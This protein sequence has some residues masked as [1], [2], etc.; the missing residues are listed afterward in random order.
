[1]IAESLACFQIYHTIDRLFYEDEIF[2][3]GNFV[4]HPVDDVIERV[5]CQFFPKYTRGRPRA[6]EWYPGWP[7]WI[8]NSR[9]NEKDRASIKIKNWAACIPEELRKSNFMTTVPFD[10]APHA[11]RLHPSP[12]KQGVVPGSRGVS[13]GIGGALG[14]YKGAV[15]GEDEDA[16]SERR[17]QMPTTMTM[18]GSAAP[19]PVKR[20]VGRPPK[21]RQVQ[22]EDSR[23]GRRMGSG[24]PFGGSYEGSP[25]PAPNAGT[26]YGGHQL[27]AAG[28]YGYAPPD[29][30]MTM[31]GG[32]GGPNGAGGPSSMQFNPY[33]SQGGRGQ[34]LP[35]G[36]IPPAPGHQPMFNPNLP[37]P[38]GPPAG[39]SPRMP[40]GGGAPL[41][42]GMPMHPMHHQQ[43]IPSGVGPS[44]SSSSSLPPALAP[45]PLAEFARIYGN[46]D[47]LRRMCEV[48][49]LPAASGE[50]LSSAEG[51]VASCPSIPDGL[52]LH[53]V[54]L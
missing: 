15:D 29:Y 6:P 26:P 41:P 23:D 34:P 50:C 44:S 19:P 47:Q 18:A 49:E 2:K 27:P 11:L 16:I 12:F 48:E 51:R 14:S 52:F 1:M 40:G 7:L 45:Q 31:S 22:V 39:F 46:E 8:S 53:S 21:N 5:G 36:F 33:A 9:Y 3:T 38:T 30:P 25:M 4:D 13:G 54:P 35:P 37:P 17:L 42:P 24:T 20:P 32:G 10:K 28:A 43:G